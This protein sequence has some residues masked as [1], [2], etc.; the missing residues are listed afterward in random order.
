MEW[1]V[2]IERDISLVLDNNDDFD[3]VKV[4]LVRYADSVTDLA[5]TLADYYYDAINRALREVPEKSLGY[6]LLQ[7][8]SYGIPQH[9]FDSIASSWWNDRQQVA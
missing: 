5:I 4:N 1:D 6:Q 7:E 8:L 2:Q 9:I 3:V